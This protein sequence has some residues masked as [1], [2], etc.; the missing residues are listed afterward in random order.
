MTERLVRLASPRDLGVS[1]G[2]VD[3]VRSAISVLMIGLMGLLV[4]AVLIL[5]CGLLGLAAYALAGLVR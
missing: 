4:R 5:I 3:P 2:R 1:H